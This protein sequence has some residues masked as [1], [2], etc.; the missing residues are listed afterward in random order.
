MRN[1]TAES[2]IVVPG[3]QFYVVSVEDTSSVVPGM[4]HSEGGRSQDC[5]DMQGILLELVP[6]L[7]KWMDVFYFSQ[8]QEAS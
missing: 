3:P 2:V 6:I 5:C 1:E 7:F 4:Q 8:A